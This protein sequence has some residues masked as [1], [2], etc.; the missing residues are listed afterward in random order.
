MVVSSVV[1]GTVTERNESQDPARRDSTCTVQKQVEYETKLD[2]HM[3][4][5]VRRGMP[6]S[7]IQVKEARL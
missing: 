2:E 7:I 5:D 3:M 1:V 6:F 4:E